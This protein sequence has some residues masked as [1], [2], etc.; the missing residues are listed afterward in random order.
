MVER[1]VSR[2]SPCP[3]LVFWAEHLFHQDQGQAMCQ[4]NNGLSNYLISQAY[5]IQGVRRSVNSTFV[6]STQL[7]KRVLDFPFQFNSLWKV[8]Q[9]LTGST[10]LSRRAVLPLE[11]NKLPEELQTHPPYR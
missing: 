6:L 4:T 9:D 10:M 8:R 5:L 1:Y 11:P 7:S 2:F 3:Y